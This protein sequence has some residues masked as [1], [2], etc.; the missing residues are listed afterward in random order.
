MKI[1][2]REHKQLQRIFF[3]VRTKLSSLLTTIFSCPWD[4]YYYSF[5]FCLAFYLTVSIILYL[6]MFIFMLN[7]L[8]SVDSDTLYTIDIYRCAM[9]LIMLVAVSKKLWKDLCQKCF[10]T[11]LVCEVFRNGHLPSWHRRFAFISDQTKILLH[12]KCPPSPQMS[13]IIF[14]MH[15]FVR[16]KCID[17]YLSIEMFTK[18]NAKTPTHDEKCIPFVWLLLMICR[19]N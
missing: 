12:E 5:S 8:C 4:D 18:I 9:A 10:V 1:R 14:N 15:S 3:T 17:N 7:A 2:Q 13:F 16:F 6:F 19:M 11:L